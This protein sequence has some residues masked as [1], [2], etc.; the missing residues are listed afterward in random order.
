MVQ[1]F[2]YRVAWPAQGHFPGHHKSHGGE[3]GLEFRC[4]AP[5]LAAPD[6]RRLDLRAS[7]RNPFGEWIVRLYNQHKSIP[8]YLVADLSGSMGSGGA[9]RQLD[10]LADFAEALAYSAYRTGDP[11][12]FI[13]CNDRIV[14]DLLLPPTRRKGIGASLAQTLRRLEPGRKD[15]AA[16]ADAHTLTGRRRAL[17]FLA[18]DFHLPPALVDRTLA[19]LCRHD[20]I[21]VVL[22]R[23]EEFSDA[24]RFGI[25]RL[26]DAETGRTRTLLLRPALRQKWAD[27]R[28]ARAASL[29]ALFRVH[30]LRP[31]RLGDCFRPEVVSAY[32]AV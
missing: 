21:P 6:P 22:G 7:L 8:V 5:F 29:D 32:F 13:G 15:A 2:H 9:T 11:F 30:D 23:S 12:G 3:S 4:H 28:A 10:V 27:E 14:D 20:V 1:E 25:A 18:S 17:V 26:E 19:S 24:P 31:L 16:L